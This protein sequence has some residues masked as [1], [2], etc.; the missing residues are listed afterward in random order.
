MHFF[1]L[2]LVIKMQDAVAKRKESC[3]GNYKQNVFV[4]YILL[5]SSV[6]FLL[7]VSW[8]AYKNTK[9]H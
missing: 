9:T 3:M 2:L 6:I 8:E 1:V 5:C 7:K 4:V